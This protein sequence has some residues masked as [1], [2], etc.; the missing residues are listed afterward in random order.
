[1]EQLL[2]DEEKCVMKKLLSQPTELI[3]LEREVMV[4]LLQGK[5]PILNI[6]YQQYLVSKV[7]DRNLTGVGFFTTFVVP[8]NVR[9]VNNESFAFGDVIAEVSG[10]KHGIGFVLFVKSGIIDT[11]EGYTYDETWPSKITNLR[12]S[13]I[14]NKRELSSFPTML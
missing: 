5:N 3:A 1:M 9:R 4:S 7:R 8:E 10:L 14:K 6:L 2:N 11:L 13:Y 12:V